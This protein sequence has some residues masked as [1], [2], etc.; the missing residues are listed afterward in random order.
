MYCNRCGA[1]NPH[2]SS[3]CTRCGSDLRR[4]KPVARTRSIGTTIAAIVTVLV[5]TGSILALA[6]VLGQQEASYA[7]RNEQAEGGPVLE[8]STTCTTD[9]GS[10]DSGSTQTNLSDTD[11]VLVQN[12]IDAMH[13]ND[14]QDLSKQDLEQFKPLIEQSF[15]SLRN[16]PEASEALK[17]MEQLTESSSTATI[18]LIDEP[19]IER[20]GDNG[21]SVTVRGKLRSDGS[22]DMSFEDVWNLVMSE[23][24][25]ITSAEVNRASTS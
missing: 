21:V 18:G 23:T 16:V 10:S 11:I 13:C 24:G 3:H 1:K 5:L 9:S 15:A 6:S 25:K 8:T 19:K 4:R 7:S 14:L 22:G 17:T 12:F 20:I 2:S